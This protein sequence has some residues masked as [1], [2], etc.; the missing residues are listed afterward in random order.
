MNKQK[1]EI[2]HLHIAFYSFLIYPVFYSHP[3]LKNNLFN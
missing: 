1:E 3:T 2:Y